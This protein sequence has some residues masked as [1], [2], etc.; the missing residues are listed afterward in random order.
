[1]KS[2]SH[3]PDY[4]TAEKRETMLDNAVAKHHNF[5]ENGKTRLKEKWSYTNEDI[6]LAQKALEDG[7]NTSRKWYKK[8]NAK[9]QAI[10]DKYLPIFK[11]A[12]AVAKAVDVSDIK[13]GFPCGSAHL[14]LDEYPEDEELR[15]ALGH[16][17]SSTS[18]SPQWKYQLDKIIKM[19]SYGQCVSFDERICEQVRTFLRTKGIF[20]NIHSY[21]D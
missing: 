9:Y 5:T 14:Y 1:M 18:D 2:N 12:E 19:P 7:F 17:T 15:R 20:V 21:I 10:I 16:F 13:D 4:D 6:Q 3:H 11:E 8:A